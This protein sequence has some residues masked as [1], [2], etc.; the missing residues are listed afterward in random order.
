MGWMSKAGRLF[1]SGLGNNTLEVIDI[2]TGK[3]I[4]SRKV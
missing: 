4:K 1:V 2:K 3:V